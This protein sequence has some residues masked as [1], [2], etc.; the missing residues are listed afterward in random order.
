[1][2][3]HSRSPLRK[4]FRPARSG[5]DSARRGTGQEKRGRGGGGTQKRRGAA[6]IESQAL[7]ASSWQPGGRRASRRKAVVPG[8]GPSASRGA[9]SR[10]DHSAVR[11]SGQVVRGVI[12]TA[13]ASWR[14]PF[15]GGAT[16]IRAPRGES[17]HFRGSERTPGKGLGPCSAAE[18]T[19]RPLLD[20]SQ[21]SP[22]AERTP[23]AH[24]P[25]VPQQGLGTRQGRRNLGS[26]PCGRHRSRKRQSPRQSQL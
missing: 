2:P 14:P 16:S 10:G 6:I 3:S 21:R 17:G 23:P 24:P 25:Q 1:M 26:E 15:A 12:T 8:A 22:I 5:A 7:G 19:R 4:G 11:V 18:S 20:A 13:F 9:R